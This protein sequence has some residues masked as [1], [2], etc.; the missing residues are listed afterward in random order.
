MLRMW[1]LVALWVLLAVMV[2]CQEG[3]TA[4]ERAQLQYFTPAH[5]RVTVTD[6]YAVAPPDTI[7]IRAPLAPELNNVKQMIAPDGTLNLDLL[8]RVAVAGKSPQEI[9]DLLTASL[10][11]YYKDVKVHVDIDYKS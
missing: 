10:R 11:T 5:T 6:R 1:N 4:K 2:G 3:P 8:G 9:E 7:T